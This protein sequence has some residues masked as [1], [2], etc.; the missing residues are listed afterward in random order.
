[1]VFSERAREVLSL[2]AGEYNDYG[3]VE[4]EK[5]PDV[6][7]IQW[8]FVHQDVVDTI[9]GTMGIDTSG[10]PLE[11]IRAIADFAFVTRTPLFVQDWLLGQ[12]HGNQHE[13]NA[14]RNLIK[15]TLSVLQ[16]KDEE[17]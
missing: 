16:A 10:D 7:R 5:H 3:W 14:Q 6:E 12:Q 15:I 8:F 2:I 9:C 4:G 1:M 11:V 13:R 17:D